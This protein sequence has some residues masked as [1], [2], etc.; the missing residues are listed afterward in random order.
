MSTKAHGEERRRRRL[1]HQYDETTLART[2]SEELRLSVMRGEERER[3][4]EG[5]QLAASLRG[6][7]GGVRIACKG[8]CYTEGRYNEREV[9]RRSLGVGR[10]ASI[11][12]VE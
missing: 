3:I 12:G 1:R 4:G 7:N 2:I 8:V 11:S 5:I 6:F 10:S 9:K